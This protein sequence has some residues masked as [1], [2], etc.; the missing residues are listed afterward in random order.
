MIYLKLFAIGVVAVGLVA[1]LAAI[2]APAWLCAI[3]CMVAIFVGYI[4]REEENA[5]TGTYNRQTKTLHLNSRCAASEKLIEIKEYK[6]TNFK[7]N[8]A[9]LVY[10]GATVGGISMGG[11]HVNEAHYSASSSEKTGRYELHYKGKGHCPIEA[12]FCHFN[13]GNNSCVKKFKTSDNMLKL[14][15]NEATPKIDAAQKKLLLQATKNNDLTL[16]AGL[17]KDTMAAQKLTK[18]ECE[19]IKAWIGGR[20]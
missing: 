12:I 17:T 4:L 14:I 9:E 1:L 19:N 6:H 16:M 15:H 7:Y 20:M 2:G 8:P 10:T 5:K 18:K 11:F 3:L 13:I